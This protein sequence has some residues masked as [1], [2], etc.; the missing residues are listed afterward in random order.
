MRRIVTTSFDPSGPALNAVGTALALQPDGQKIVAVGWRYRLD[1]QNF[2]PSSG[3][4]L[5][6]YTLDGSLDTT[7]SGD[8][9]YANDHSG[10]NGQFNDGVVLPDNSIWAAGR[11]EKQSLKC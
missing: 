7:F 6:R 1:D 5:A 4:A 3:I 10:E 11:L 8:G 9:I 2:G